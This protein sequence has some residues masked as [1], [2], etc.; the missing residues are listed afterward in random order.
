MLAA[1]SLLQ[2]ITG[3]RFIFSWPGA[4]VAATI[5]AML[6]I[7]QTVRVSFASLSKVMEGA[8]QVDCSNLGQ[9]FR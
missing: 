8:A 4:V 1:G 9:T 3:I 7:V 5:A 2:T 6:L